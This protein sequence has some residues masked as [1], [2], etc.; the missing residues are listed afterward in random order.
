MNKSKT[1][2]RQALQLP[3]NPK[4]YYGMIIV[5]QSNTFVILKILKF[6]KIILID[7]LPL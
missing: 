6:L 1:T 4:E 5:R 2:N 7:T 3:Q